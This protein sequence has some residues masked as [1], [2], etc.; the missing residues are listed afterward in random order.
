MSNQDSAVAPV[1]VLKRDLPPGF[2]PKFTTLDICVASEMVAGVETILGCQQIRSLIHIYPSTQAARN[3]LLT[4]GLEIGGISVTIYDTNPFSFGGRGETPATKVWLGGIPISFSNT[5]D[6]EAALVRMGCT[7]RSRVMLEKSR[8]REGNITRFL[9]GRRFAFIS[10]PPKPLDREM[11]L[12]NI[13][14]TIWHKEQPKTNA[15]VRCG[16]CLQEGHW[17]ANCGNEVIC[18]ACKK[19]GHKEGDPECRIDDDVE[20]EERKSGSEDSSEYSTDDS[21]EEESSENEDKDE[22][23]QTTE[24]PASERPIDNALPAAVK[25][26][27]TH[28]S[29]DAN[30]GSNAKA[31]LE[32]KQSTTKSISS[33][34]LSP[35]VFPNPA[36]S[37]QNSGQPEKTKAAKRKTDKDRKSR[38][39]QLT[40]EFQT[41]PRSPTPSKRRREKGDTPTQEDKQARLQ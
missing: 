31:V 11:K 25:E 17:S 19:P 36:A 5:T 4:K 41:R 35:G 40:L 18:R 3:A 38:E 10:V 23:K 2:E 22:D 9:T 12:G 8:D 37:T 29:P 16:K 14:A 24:R 34:S 39:K 27:S 1:F 30:A 33:P 20:E 13:T 32:N 28:T 15:I 6:I 21:S 26:P 7:L